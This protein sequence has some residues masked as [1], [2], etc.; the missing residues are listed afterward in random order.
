ME[1]SQTSVLSFACY[2]HLIARNNIIYQWVFCLNNNNVYI[3]FWFIHQC[4]FELST[5]C[6]PRF[7][8]PCKKSNRTFSPGINNTFDAAGKEMVITVNGSD[9]RVVIRRY[10]LHA[11]RMQT[12]S[13]RTWIGT[14]IICYTSFWRKRKTYNEIFGNNTVIM[15]LVYLSW[16]FLPSFWNQKRRKNLE[17]IRETR[18]LAVVFNMFK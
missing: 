2:I 14:S 8:S 9:V 7:T 4:L 13:L 10:S 1:I 11:S 6:L 18:W 3:A 16:G 15:R 17:L 12:A 5:D